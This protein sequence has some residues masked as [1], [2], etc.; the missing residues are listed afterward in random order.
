[1]DDLESIAESERLGEAAY[2]AMYDARPHGV[3]DCYEDALVHF[4]R[5]IETARRAHLAN[6]VTRL[7]RRAEH[8]ERVYNRQFRGVGR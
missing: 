2:A 6:E 3:K 5:A 1:V 7:S 4:G 8:I